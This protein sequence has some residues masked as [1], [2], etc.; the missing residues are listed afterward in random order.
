M[1]AIIMKWL[2]GSGKS[3]YVMNIN[4][5]WDYCAISMD[6]IRL[7]IKKEK[8]VKK[9]QSEMIAELASNWLDIIIDNTH[10]NPKTMEKI[11]NEC[12]WLW[13]EIEVKDMREEFKDDYEYLRI[14]LERNALRELPKR[15]P[16]SVIHEMFLYEYNI[17][18]AWVHKIYLFDIDW[19]IADWTHRQH[20]VEHEN[21]RDKNR[22]KYF[23]LMGK[24][25]PISATIDILNSL[26]L[27]SPFNKIIIL[28]W[29]PNTYYD[30][31]KKWLDENQI[32]Y[33]HILMRKS[34]DSRRDDIIKEDIYNRCLKKEKQH[35]IWVFDDR[36]QV[37]EMWV[38]NWVFVFDV[39]QTD[40]VF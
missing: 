34:W 2:P 29:R 40:R 1:K 11:K 21:Q 30:E 27:F 36:K 28:T 31:T 9:K 15:V 5:N 39:N 8:N 38:R 20:Y 10:C 14:C 18:N 6:T 32:T 23:S 35:I 33:D 7:F 16:D 4:I 22:P 12:K 13:Y 25:T 17:S 37:K 26:K 24:D 19:T 3:T